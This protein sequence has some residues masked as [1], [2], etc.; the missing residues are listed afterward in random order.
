MR[1]YG[2]SESELQVIVDP[3]R[4]AAYRLTVS[5][6]VAALRAA[7]VATSAG[8]VNDGKRRYLVRVDGNLVTPERVAAVL[9]RS[10]RDAAGDRTARV[11]VGDVAEIVFG[12]KRPTMVLRSMGEPAIS[13]SLM[14]E[15][16]TNIMTAMDKVRAEIDEM[17]AT[18]LPREGLRLRIVYD[19][20]DYVRQAIDLVVQNI[21]VG[22]TLAALVL[23]AFLRSA[24]ATLVISLAI[25]ISTIGTFVGMTLLGRTINVISMAGLSFAV[26]MVVDAAIV[27]LENIYRYREQ[28]LSRARAAEAGARQVWGAVLASSL[29]K[30]V[31]FVPLLLMKQETGQMFRDIAVAISVS[32]ALSMLVAI[33]V[34]PVLAR[35]LLGPRV[36]D[37]APLAL[38]LLDGVARAFSAALE[39]ALAR[40]TADRKSALIAVGGITAACL[41]LTFPLLPKLEYL[42]EGNRNM[43]FGS[44][45]PPPGYNLTTTESTAERIENAVR[46]L[47]GPGDSARGAPP[48]IDNFS[49]RA[50]ESGYI[51]VSATAADPTR[52]AE[53]IPLMQAPIFDEPGTYGYMTQPSLFSRR[54]GS[55]RSIDIDI[56]GD[57]M[58]DVAAV[59][60]RVNATLERVFPRRAGYQMQPRPGLELGAPEVRLTPDPVRLR[61]AGVSA[62]DFARSID[63][64]NDGMRV[65]EINVANQ[66]IDLTL[67]GRDNVHDATQDIAK[68]PVVT[69]DGTVV[70]AASLSEVEVTEGPTEI[71]HTEGRRT[72]TLQLRPPNS[73]A[74]QSAIERLRA[75]VVDPAIREGLP[76]GIRIEVSGVAGKLAATWSELIWQL[77]IAGGVVYLIMAVLFESLLY[78]LIIMITMPMASAGA[79]VCLGLL[80]LFVYTPLDMLTMLGFVI[81]IGTVVNNAILLVDQSLFLSRK[82]G[83]EMRRAVALASRSRVRPIF[84]STLTSLFGMAPLVLFPGAGTEL[85]RG[86]GAVVLGG[87]ALST[88]LTLLVVPALMC[89]VSG[90]RTGKPA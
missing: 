10:E 26:G 40:I 57:D 9:L 19:Q 58:E 30:I 13:F 85:Y 43:A 71:R 79:L 81:L 89:L 52:V 77:L 38:P 83:L 2:G 5:D 65:L 23:F 41:A 17:N 31:V 73:V 88:F 46:P 42:P 4:L 32:I 59:A 12:H 72:I 35:R 75:E 55:G 80:N 60:R 70:R 18:L 54:S 61:D 90:T 51:E 21:Y 50:Y 68:L 1:V 6:V 8:F 78:P 34:V 84:M 45:R 69:A 48:R 49:F 28:G 7:D 74:L 66:R 44:V 87:L 3:T 64:F 82:E 86:L 53:L 20:T 14:A 25:P 27:V 36:G 37:R 29:T 22:G 39:G 24:R 16:D 56:S 62:S 33:T 63:V 11:T 76:D 47:W 15:T 67:K